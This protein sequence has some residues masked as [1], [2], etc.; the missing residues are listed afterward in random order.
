M[1]TTIL[2]IFT[3]FL[4]FSPLN[5]EVKSQ[6]VSA[7]KIRLNIKN[8]PEI[9][10]KTATGPNSYRID[11]SPTI[12]YKLKGNYKRHPLKFNPT[13]KVL[14]KVFD[15]DTIYLK[16]R[17][18]PGKSQ[19]YILRR[20]D[21]A[22][23][24][25][26]NGRP[27][28]KVT[29]R[30]FKK[31]DEDVLIAINKFKASDKRIFISRFLSNKTAKKNAKKE[32]I[33]AY[34]KILISLD[35]LSRNHLLSNAEYTYYK[36]LITYKKEL[37]TGVFKLNLLK[38]GDLHV[39]GYELYLR[40]YVFSNLKKKIISLGNGMARNT[41]EG[42]DFVFTSNNFSID[43]KRHLLLKYLTSIK[44]LFPSATYKNRYAKYQSSVSQKN[45]QP[46]IKDDSEFLKSI[47]KTTEDVLLVDSKNNHTTLKEVIDKNKGKI[48]YIDFWASWCAPCRQAFPSYKTLKKEY[49]EKDIV[50]I[51]I[52][53][54]KD[55]SKWKKAEAKE[56]L[57]NSY[58]SV[59]YLKVKFY[60]YLELNSFPRYLIFNQNGQLIKDR[61]PGP[62][63]DIIRGYFNELLTD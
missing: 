29:N 1:K 37:K 24:E 8:I 21:N 43:N 23:I 26:V 27:N 2:F 55:S 44:T 20:G 42:F 11:K 45:R 36:K 7:S 35:S 13:K 39:E 15:Q 31:H 50:Y 18:N 12:T 9:K 14:S 22:T 6:S 62:D 4:L 16:L 5:N 57:T 41:L 47:Y 48:I 33:K 30:Q 52:S 63:S 28:L 32:A 60:K 59:N 34:N 53:G 10:H 46:P 17:Y 54:D 19:M 40:Q 49:N 25:Y 61:A 51:F 38:K 58:L 56:K 3:L